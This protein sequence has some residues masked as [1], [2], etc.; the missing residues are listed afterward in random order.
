[1]IRR[2]QWDIWICLLVFGLLVVW[3]AAGLDLAVMRGLG[4][5]TGFTWHSSTLLTQVHQDSRAIAWLMLAWQGWTAFGP[6][7]WVTRQ[8]T[9]AR[10]DRAHQRYWFAVTL[11]CVATINVIKYSSNTSC[12]WDL[13]EFGGAAR[14]VSHWVFWLP[15]GGPGACFPSGHSS[16]AFSFFTLYFVWRNCDATRAKRCVW[17]VFAFGLVVSLTQIVRGAHYPSHALWTAWLCWTICCFADQ[18]QQRLK[19]IVVTQLRVG[20]QVQL[21]AD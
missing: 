12:P 16:A 19:E 9:G 20:Q 18:W 5:A 8:A 3:D 17:A 4:D 21:K 1:M 11:I 7:R 6:Q 2:S 15:D 14:H 10:L 13:A